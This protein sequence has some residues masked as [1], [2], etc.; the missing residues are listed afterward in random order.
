[1][2]STTQP[3]YAPAVTNNQQTPPLCDAKRIAWAM[4]VSLN[5]I[6]DWLFKGRMFSPDI[7]SH[8]FNRW[9]AQTIESFIADPITW[10][11]QNGV[12]MKK[13][14]PTNQKASRA[15]GQRQ[16]SAKST[17]CAVQRQRILQALKLRPQHSYELR[18]MGLYMVNA[19]VCELRKE[20]FRITTH[21][22]VA[23]DDQ[24]YRRAG[25]ALYSLEGGG[26]GE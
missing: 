5:A 16:Y 3:Q 10:R 7:R 11:E 15:H 12:A 4:G 13:K 17:T 26:N 6:K 18:K 8:R 25:V 9:K 19:R 22:T 23:I 2:Y 20:G 24:G 21:R 14:N 1:M